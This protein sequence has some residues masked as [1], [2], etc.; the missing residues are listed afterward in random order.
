MIVRVLVKFFGGIWKIKENAKISKIHNR[1]FYEYFS[2]KGSYIGHTTEF[3]GIPIFPH[4]VLSVFISGSAKIGKNV[5]IYQQVTIGSNTLYD[6]KGK[7]APTIGDNVLIG[8]GAKII[9]NVKIGNNVRI[10]ANAVVV[11]DIPDN[12]LVVNGEVRI[13]QK[14]TLVNKFYSKNSFNEWV[15]FEDEKQIKEK[16]EEVLKK[17]NF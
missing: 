6:S 7:G 1:I 13:I 12:C 14:D 5:I 8:A 10:G 2:E 15:Y 11:K 16:D 17:L 9:G 3:K 4:G